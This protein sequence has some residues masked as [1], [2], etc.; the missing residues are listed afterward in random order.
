MF[1]LRFALVEPCARWKGIPANERRLELRT[2]LASFHNI[3]G[4]QTGYAGWLSLVVEGFLDSD[5]TEGTK[6]VYEIERG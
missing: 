6:E 1:F 3:G 5:E 4:N 2:S